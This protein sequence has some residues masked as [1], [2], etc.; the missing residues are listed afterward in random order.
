[1][2]VGRA[3]IR[4]GQTVLVLGANSGVG[5]AGIQI[6]K[7]FHCRVIATAGDDRKAERARELGADFVINHYQQKIS[8]EVRKI[9]SKEGVDI[10]MEHVGAATWDESVRSLKPGGTL[11]TCGA[12]SG[13]EAKVDLRFLFSRQLSL[14]GSYMGTMSELHDAMK[15]VFSG[16]LKP[17]VDRAF[18]LSETRA[19]HEYMEKSQM[20]GK[21]VLNP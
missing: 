12:T 14:V 17:V 13:F 20:F 8:E 10:V 6:A 7:L 9:T 4:P 11:V 15:H 3:G 5:I 2:L 18:P 19:A 16:A 1:M 21:I